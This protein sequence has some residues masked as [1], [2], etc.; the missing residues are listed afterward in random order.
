VVREIHILAADNGKVGTEGHIETGSTYDNIELDNFTC[1][2]L[3]SL[4]DYFGDGIEDD[5]GILFLES[6]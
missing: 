2:K 5:T 3:D 6:L 4:L 1:F